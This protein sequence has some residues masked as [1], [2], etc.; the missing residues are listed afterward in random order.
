MKCKFEPCD[1]EVRA[2]GLCNAHYRQ[3]HAGKELKPL[4]DRTSFQTEKRCPNC[5]TTKPREDFYERKGGRLQSHC[6]ECMIKQSH[7]RNRR[8]REALGI[9]AR[10]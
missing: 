10:F 9:Q 5:E 8:M 1:R 6:I 7:D 4:L 2:R 3:Q